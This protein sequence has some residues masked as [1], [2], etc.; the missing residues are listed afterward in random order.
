MGVPIKG[1]DQ[2][3]EVATCV[4]ILQNLTPLAKVLLDKVFVDQLGSKELLLLLQVLQ[5]DEIWQ[6]FVSKLTTRRCLENFQKVV[7]YIFDKLV[8]LCLI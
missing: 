6:V 8:F 1:P 7:F 4:R 2:L 3:Y 5:E